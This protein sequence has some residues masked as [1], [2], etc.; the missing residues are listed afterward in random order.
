ME[1]SIVINNL[2][3]SY[4][5]INIFSNFNLNIRRGKIIAFF[6]SNGCGKSTLFNILA[7]TVKKDS[8]EITLDGN[9]KFNF[10]YMFQNFQE[11]LLPWRS[12]YQ[13]LA[14]PLQIQ[15]ISK[16][17]IKNKILNIYNKYNFNINLNS[18]P[19][20]LSGG[21]KQFLLFLR[22][23]ITN[24]E[25]ILLDEPFSALDYENSFLLSNKLQ[26]YYLSEKPTILVIT[27]DIEEAVY[28][29][30]EI[31]VLS[32]RPT[33]V[34][35]IVSNPLPYPRTTDILKSEEFHKIKTKVLKIFQ[36]EVRI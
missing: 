19:Y 13:N 26:E 2:N 16:E 7:G 27:H 4:N 31:V 28:L 29:A 34:L 3:K 23:I 20:E 36:S 17:N 21:Q 5:G 9:N 18:Y 22:S 24:P 30:D 11:S 8:G 6:G 10:S 25:T 32:H 15:G 14:L 1:N 33:K 35:G 12:N